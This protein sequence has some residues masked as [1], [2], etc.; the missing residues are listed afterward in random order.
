[1]G[2]HPIFES[3]FDCLTDK[4]NKSRR[5]ESQVLQ[6]VPA[7]KIEFR[8]PFDS[9]SISSLVLKNPSERNVA[10]KIKTTAPARYCVRPNAGTVAAG[11]DAE[12]KVMLQPGGTDEKHK[13]MV[14]SIF[15]P[16]EYN[17]IE[18]KEEKK[19]FVSD[20]WTKPA[21]NPVMSSKL[22]CHFL[23]DLLQHNEDSPPPSYETSVPVVTEAA[24]EVAVK[25]EP[26]YVHSQSIEK[27]RPEP[28]KAKK[29]V[30]INEGKPSSGA[31]GQSGSQGEE[32]R[33]LTQ[34][35]RDAMRQIEILSSAP[36]PAASSS[37]QTPEQQ[38][39]F[40]ILLFVAFM[41]GFIISA[42]L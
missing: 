6:M 10:F 26:L 11:G 15:V 18:S 40:L 27:E 42:M 28:A 30:P 20:L 31:T 24:P 38:K 14:Q 2:T 37:G 34:E 21:E 29:T 19:T 9:V 7:E 4:M 36:P 3:D 25:E 12:I 35:L 8:P 16:D 13:F 23:T 39:L 5:K 33:R 22:I 17:S 32:I 41:A 1:M